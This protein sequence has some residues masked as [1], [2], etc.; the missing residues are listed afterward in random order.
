MRMLRRIGL[1]GVAILG[2]VLVL[3]GLWS[4]DPAGSQATGL[5]KPVSI[6]LFDN[7]DGAGQAG[8]D[9]YTVPADK[10][11]VVE[12]AS[13]R[14]ELP[15]SPNFE[16]TA[17]VTLIVTPA[18]GPIRIYQLPVAFQLKHDSLN[19]P[20][21]VLGSNGLIRVYAGSGAKLQAFALS[22]I[23]SGTSGA[24]NVILSGYLESV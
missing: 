18:S 22:G 2:A 10:R 24:L 13:V 4:T 6:A 19:T 17:S 16:T 21:D 12:G 3:P 9:T 11:L 20:F 7:F 5:D 14:V 8:T 1:L 23:G 15:G